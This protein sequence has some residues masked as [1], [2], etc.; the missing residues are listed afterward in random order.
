MA[1]HEE[2]REDLIAEATALVH[3]IE[4]LPGTSSATDDAVVTAGFR[5]NGFLS[6]YFGQDRFYQFDLEGCLRRAY[7]SPFVYRAQ[8]GNLCR[9]GRQRSNDRTTLVRTDLA[10]S[11]S[12]EFIEDC[13]SWLQHLLGE[14]NSGDYRILRFVVEGQ[15]TGDQWLIRK[16]QSLL[17]LVLQRQSNFF[18][19]TIAKRRMK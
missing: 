4:L 9:L 14:L 3:R 19:K 6:V 11:E 5:R 18:S 13:R 17:S 8:F 7:V 16:I 12:N 1:R 15:D 2:N 10:E